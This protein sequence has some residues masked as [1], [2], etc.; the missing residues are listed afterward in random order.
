MPFNEEAKAMLKT[1]DVADEVDF[2]FLRAAQR[3]V[4]SVR[5]ELLHRL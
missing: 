2:R 4:V 1:L 3:Y 5:D